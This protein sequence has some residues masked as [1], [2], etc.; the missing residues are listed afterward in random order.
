MIF[1]FSSDFGMTRRPRQLK[2]NPR[3][4][5][6][7]LAIVVALAVLLLLLRMIAFIAGHGH[8]RL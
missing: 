3:N 2:S 6:L 5:N 7:L 1:D 4:V 8:H